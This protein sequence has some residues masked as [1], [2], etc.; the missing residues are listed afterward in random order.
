V[1]RAADESGSAPGRRVR[2]AGGE[3]LRPSGS[4]A[5]PREEITAVPMI[6]AF[7]PE[8][9]LTPEAEATLFQ[10]LTDTLIR[11]EGFEPTNAR[12]RAATWIFLHRPQVFRAGI[13]AASP[14]YRFIL[15]VPEG[16]YDDEV[17]SAIVR[18][19]TGAVARAEG[20]PFDEVSSRVWVFPL[21]VP[22]G[23]WGGPGR[24][25][26]AARHPRVPGRRGRA[27]GGRG[28]ARRTTPADRDGDRRDGARRRPGDRGG[29]GRPPGAGD[30]SGP[31]RSS[32]AGA[33]GRARRWRA[34]ER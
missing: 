24:G 13:P 1:P 10:E 20:N 15:S 11:L 5:R 8:G 22:D 6:D 30:R 26:P 14:R 3:L 34:P 29:V 23:G 17:R 4:R 2:L 27:P 32:T 19:M 9:A 28:E 25:A 18:E 16:Q 31:A 7:I 12:A 33:G 21:E